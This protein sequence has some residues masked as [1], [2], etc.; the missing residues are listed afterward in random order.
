MLL[1]FLSLF[2]SPFYVSPIVCVCCRPS[3]WLS[4][5]GVNKNRSYQLSDRYLGN[6]QRQ[7]DRDESRSLLVHRLCRIRKGMAKYTHLHINLLF[8][9]NCIFIT[10]SATS[11]RAARLCSSHDEDC[12]MFSVVTHEKQPRQNR[13]A[14]FIRCRGNLLSTS[15][16]PSRALLKSIALMHV[17][18]CTNTVLY[19]NC[20][21]IIFFIGTDEFH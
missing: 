21:D 8:Q 13:G 14:K 9:E 10:F 15:A 17:P 4:D 19:V 5:G 20:K 7:T 1:L 12:K 2:S 11:S 16:F 6:L 3:S 18:N